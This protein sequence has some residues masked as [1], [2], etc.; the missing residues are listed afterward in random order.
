M[1][2]LIITE[3]TDIITCDIIYWE[4]IGKGKLNRERGIIIK[5]WKGITKKFLNMAVDREKN[6]K[7]ARWYPSSPSASRD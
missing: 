3:N 6:I 5:L 4:I 7:M 2:D 1:S